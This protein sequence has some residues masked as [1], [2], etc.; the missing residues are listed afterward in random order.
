MSGPR[1]IAVGAPPTF[2][3]QVARAIGSVPEAVEWLPTLAAA[4][5]LLS[6]KAGAD[7]LALS[8]S[9]ESNEAIA[10]SE[11]VTK[12]YPMSAVVLVRDLPPDGMLPSLMRSGIRDVIDL[13]AGGDDLRDA[14]DRA[15]RWSASLQALS[16]RIQSD[17]DGDAGRMVCFFSTKGGTGKTFLACNVATALAKRVGK[18]V[19][20]VDL[21]IAHGDVFSYF[22]TQPV[23]PLDD[24]L[25]AP[26]DAGE[27][28][29]IGLGNQLGDHL[30]GY[31]APPDPGAGQ[32]VSTDAVERALR[33][34]RRSFAFTVVDGTADY[35]DHVLAALDMADLIYLVTGP[36]VVGLKHLSNALQ[37]LV[38]LGTS[39]DR[40]RVVMNRA[41]SKVG[42]TPADAERA[43]GIR[44]D[45][46]V[47]SSSAVP[48][49]LNRGIPVV[50]G[51]PSS[52]VSKAIGE[53]ASTLSNGHSPAGPPR[54]NG[55]RNGRLFN[56]QGDRSVAR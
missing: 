53:I 18:P 54:A 35:S 9:V 50:A 38:T 20:L 55:K 16:G 33:T 51:E 28:T 23:R 47:P 5:D 41:D 40:I 11:L 44:A 13:S 29:V 12:R 34:L 45:A 15:L 48:L 30:W 8:P 37:T 19:A 25:S 52:G 32:S 43:L 49:S 31:A 7:V 3:Q 2:R 24:L 22:G 4:E 21:D 10:F 46:L 27:E 42:I 1:V 56:R 36:D 39:K 17:G 6:E 26:E 14:L